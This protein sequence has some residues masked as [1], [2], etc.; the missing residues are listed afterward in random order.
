[1]KRFK[2]V[3]STNCPGRSDGQYSHTVEACLK[4]TAFGGKKNKD[5]FRKS[6]PTDAFRILQS[7]AGILENKTSGTKECL[8]PKSMQMKQI[9]D[10]INAG[11]NY[12]K[13]DSK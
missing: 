13:I 9:G 12:K 6:C 3:S 4:K 2:F 10:I 8:S 5:N 11:G 1:V 7:T